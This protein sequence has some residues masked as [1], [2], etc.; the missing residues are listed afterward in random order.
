MCVRLASSGAGPLKTVVEKYRLGV[1]V[2]PDDVEEILKGAKQLLDSFAPNGKFDMGNSKS[3]KSSAAK[4]LDSGHSLFDP[5]PSE[6]ARYERENSWEQNAALVK[7]AFFE[8]ST[9]T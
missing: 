5:L 8:N 9:S 6:W 1:F 4:S 2:E 7:S 3:R